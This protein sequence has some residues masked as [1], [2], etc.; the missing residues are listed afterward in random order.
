MG[1]D[2][3]EKK[4]SKSASSEMNYIGLLDKPE[5]AKKKIMKAV[6][7]TGQEIKFDPQKKPAISNLLVIYSLLAGA[8]IKELE[9]R[10]CGK[11]PACAEASAGK[12]GEFKKDLAEVVAGFLNDFQRKYYGFE[13]KFIEEMLNKGAEKANRIANKT[14]EKVKKAIGV[15]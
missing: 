1:L 15:L 13:D 14:L 3:P 9:K 2:N 11:G 8:E 6:T 7:D 12:Y 5:A 4:M 10:Y